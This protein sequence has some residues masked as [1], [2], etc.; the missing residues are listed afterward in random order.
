MSILNKS[1]SFII[2]K[3]KSK[4][5]IENNDKDNFKS[6]GLIPVE[7]TNYLDKY[8]LI[9]NYFV[10]E[11][12]PK[13]DNLISCRMI[14]FSEDLNIDVEYV[15]KVIS[16]IT[17]KELSELSLKINKDLYFFCVKEN[18]SKYYSKTLIILSR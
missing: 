14:D 4:S 10:N 3:D 17:P 6:N 12:L 13:Y 9:N 7:L 1:K 2:E 8:D 18:I 15:F 16:E 11:I 5:F